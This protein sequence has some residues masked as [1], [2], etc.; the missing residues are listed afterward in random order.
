MRID[1]WYNY[2]YWWWD[3]RSRL[4]HWKILECDSCRTARIYDDMDKRYGQTQ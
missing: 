2:H 4:C 1:A 3:V